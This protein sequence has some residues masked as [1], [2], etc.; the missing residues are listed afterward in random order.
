MKKQTAIK[1]SMLVLAVLATLF[2]C[3][4]KIALDHHDL[5]N[6]PLNVCPVCAFAQIL[7]FAEYPL[8]ELHIAV[9]YCLVD[10][11]HP[12]EKSFIQNQ[13]N[14]PNLQNRAPPATVIG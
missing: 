1:Q 13:V 10:I 5:D 2:V 7:S 6:L 4:L 9:N 3:N 11:Q 12:V 14:L 8:P